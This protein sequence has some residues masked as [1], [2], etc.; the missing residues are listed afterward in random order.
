MG[1]KSGKITLELEARYFSQVE[2]RNAVVQ[3]FQNKGENCKAIDHNTIQ[4]NNKQYS[5][6]EWNQSVGGVPV[7]QAI[8]KEVN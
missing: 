5:V 1:F 4:L 8:L 7:Q 2:L 6:N 3:H